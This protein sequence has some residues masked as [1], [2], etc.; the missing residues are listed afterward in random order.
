MTAETDPFILTLEQ[1]DST[2]TYVREHFD[3][4]PDLALVTAKFQTAGRGRLGRKWISPPGL[5]FCG[6]FCFKNLSNG[7]H[8]GMICGTALMRMAAELLPEAP[9]FL[10][11]PN[12]LYCGKAKVAGM[13]GEGVIRQGRIAGV[14]MGIGL[15]VNTSS[16]DLAAAGQSALSL[17][18]IGEREFNVDF[19]AKLLAKYLNVCYIKYSNSVPELFSEWRSCNK[20]IGKNLAVTDACGV[21]YE[22]VFK[23]VTSE[24]EMVL[25]YD[26]QGVM[27]QKHFNCAD[28]S[29]DKSSL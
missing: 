2:N 12:D 6:S 8:A 3:E 20:L 14:V 25:E 4:L 29:V 15:N 22:G 17:K 5:N 19:V 9:F 16:R 11:W 27:K 24:G 26:D 18:L 7:F 13:L 23:D 28:V 1:T 10:K 21:R